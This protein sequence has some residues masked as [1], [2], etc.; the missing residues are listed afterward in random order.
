MLPGIRGILSGLNNLRTV[1]FV[2]S[3]TD[4]GS[5]STTKTIAGAALGDASPDRVVICAFG[6]AGGA[7][8]RQILSATINGEAATILV[9]SISATL[10]IDDDL[11]IALFAAEVPSGTTGDI[12]IELSSSGADASS[13]GIWAARGMLSL[14]P[15]DTDWNTTMSG[16]TLNTEPDGFAI[17]ACIFRSA[18]TITWTNAAEDYDDLNLSSGASEVTDGSSLTITPTLSASSTYKA[19][20]A[21]TF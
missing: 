9:Q 17:A 13:C 20:V 4:S 14:T 10:N 7:P 6:S 21:A 18:N 8:E 5:V 12:V 19:F 15:V 2:T 3:I 11:N 16:L 1:E